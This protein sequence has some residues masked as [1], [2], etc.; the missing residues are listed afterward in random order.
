MLD[1]TDGLRI[2]RWLQ[3]CSSNLRMLTLCLRDHLLVDGGFASVWSATVGG[4]PCLETL[5]LDLSRNAVGDDAF[6][7]PPTAGS[8]S[9]RRFT[10]VHNRDE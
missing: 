4:M 3:Q 6:L 8:S 9:L 10:L 1:E 7:G 2:G 5:E